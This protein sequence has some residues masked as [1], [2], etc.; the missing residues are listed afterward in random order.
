MSELSPDLYNQISRACVDC[1]SGM[2]YFPGPRGSLSINVFCRNPKCRSGFNIV[3]MMRLAQRI[4]KCTI[5]YPGDDDYNGGY[6]APRFCRTCDDLTLHDH[7]HDTA[8]DISE[9]HMAGSERFVC[10]HCGLTTHAND[11]GACH[12]I[13]V[14]DRK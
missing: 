12:F 13:F 7:W 9:T 6:K 14:M 11:E 8:H 3:P 10:Q 1:G 5:P 4:G 2:G